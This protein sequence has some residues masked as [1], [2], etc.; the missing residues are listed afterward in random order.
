[1]QCSTTGGISGPGDALL[2][3]LVLLVAV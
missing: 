3:R 1:L 2:L